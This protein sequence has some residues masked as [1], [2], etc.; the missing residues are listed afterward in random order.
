MTTIKDKER[1]LND[2]LD[3]NDN[4][5]G[6]IYL[7]INMINEKM[8]VGQ[9][10]SHRK[11][12]NKYRPFGYRG[13]FKD[14]LSEARCQNKENQ[15]V[16]LN[17]AIRKYGE[18][19]FISELILRCEP[20]ELDRYEQSYI[21]SYQTLFP[22]GY[23]LTIGG[24]G[25]FYV[26]SIPNNCI[27]VE[28]GDYRHSEETKKKISIRLK[29]TMNTLECRQ[30][31]SKHACHQHDSDKLKRFANCKIDQNHLEQYLH[32]IH[33]LETGQISYYRIHIDGKRVDFRGKFQTLDELKER[34][35]S[36]LR[37]ISSSSSSAK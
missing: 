36:F 8:Y 11:N 25:Q 24:K 28:K 10:V 16:Y 32:P 22:Q 7:I 19:Q 21:D 3:T 5:I 18:D 23:N 20:S 27:T 14:H 29:Q 15:S 37:Q 12:H 2:L 33:S 17:N 6:E 1:Y 26:A 31:L 9:T 30:L 13:R 34:A 4:V 35:L